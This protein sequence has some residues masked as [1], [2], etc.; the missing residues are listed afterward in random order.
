MIAGLKTVE[1]RTFMDHAA[2]K[3]DAAAQHSAG[4]NFDDSMAKRNFI[5]W[6]LPVVVSVFNTAGNTAPHGEEVGGA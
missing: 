1:L 3:R 2:S 6:Q 4:R 5:G